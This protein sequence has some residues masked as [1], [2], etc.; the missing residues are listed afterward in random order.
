MKKLLFFVLIGLINSVFCNNYQIKSIE[1]PYIAEF[2]LRTK[3]IANNNDILEKWDPN[4]IIY[5]KKGT[6]LP[7]NIFLQGEYFHLKN[8]SSEVYFEKDLYLRIADNNFFISDDLQNWKTALEFFA[9]NC[10][11]GLVTSEENSIQLEIGAELNKR[12]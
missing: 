9:G 7:I 2:L 8:V 4:D 5:L 11:M 6:K 1:D 12:Q 10:S 3:D